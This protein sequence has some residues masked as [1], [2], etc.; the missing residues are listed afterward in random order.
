MGARPSSFKKG[1]GFLSGVDATI[2][3]YEYFTGETVQIKRGDRKGEDFTPLHLV[4]T[5]R[6]DGADEDVSQRLLIGDASNFGEVSEDGKTLFTPERQSFGR[7][8][9][10]GI[11]VESLIN[12]V[13]GGDGFPDY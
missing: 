13:E 1:G 11:F 2:T 10:A 3:G 4:P 8:S 6:V 9:E 7:N 5:F 12:P